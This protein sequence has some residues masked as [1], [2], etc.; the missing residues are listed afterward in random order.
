MKHSTFIV[1]IDDRLIHGQVIVGWV[2]ALNLNNIIV[3]NNIIL[4]DNLKMQMMKLAIPSEINVEFLS[5]ERSIEDYKLDKWVKYESIM[6]FESPKDACF[7]ISNDCKIKKLNVGG[8][9]VREDR[10]PFTSNLALNQKDI[11]YL[12]KIHK[13]GV[14]MEGRA[15]PTDEQ[16]KVIKI[17]EGR[18]NA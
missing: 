2:K 3:V 4:H 6:L 8:L 11:G 10:L 13:L 7:F 18:S 15:L 16:Y 14:E 9:H 1:R 17:I 5:L 12:K